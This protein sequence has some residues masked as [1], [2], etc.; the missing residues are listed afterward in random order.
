[1]HVAAALHCEVLDLALAGQY[2]VQKMKAVTSF[3]TRHA[4]ACS[5]AAPQTCAN[6]A[7]QVYDLSRKLLSFFLC[8]TARGPGSRAPGR[9]RVPNPYPKRREDKVRGAPTAHESRRPQLPAPA[10]QVQQR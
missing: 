7:A 9:S 2:Q 1:M 6:L 8:E 10:G 3:Q 4:S 5:T